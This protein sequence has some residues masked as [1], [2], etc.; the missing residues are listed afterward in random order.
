MK[1]PHL[2]KS[3]EAWVYAIHISLGMFNNAYC[4]TELNSSIENVKSTL[5]WEDDSIYVPIVNSIVMLGYFISNF[6]ILG[7]SDRYGRRGSMILEHSLVIVGSVLSIIP[8]TSTIIIGRALKGLGAGGFFTICAPYINEISP[9]ALAGKLGS[10]VCVSCVFGLA[11]STGLS[12]FLPSQNYST[13][14][15]NNLW[16][17]NLGFPGI[18]SIY[19]L[20][21]FLFVQKLDSPGWYLSNNQKPEAIKALSIIYTAEGIQ[22][23]LDR[24][25]LKNTE[26]LLRPKEKT[27]YFSFIFQRRNR[28]MM[29][30]AVLLTLFKQFT[31]INVVL[32]YSTTIFKEVSGDEFNSR[33]IS[34]AITVINIFSSLFGLVLLDWFGRKTLILIGQGGL[35]LL[36]IL[37]ALFSFFEV[38][39]TSLAICMFLY[40]FIA[41]PTIGS[42]YW[43]FLSETE[44][45]I[46]ISLVCVT[47]TLVTFV[48]MFVFEW[49]IEAFTIVGVFAALAVGSF[50]GVWYIRWDV[51]ETKGKRKAEIEDCLYE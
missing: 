2:Y 40:I 12:L 29:R 44:N 35:G 14:P 42:A 16:M 23:G 18:V 7:Y 19:C 32:A 3:K 51:F 28:K 1:E 27:G 50:V 4:F 11:C 31:G 10:L 30:L 25:K 47:N 41:S 15:L 21:Y 37:F 46:G 49:S 20:Y 38:G 22:S 13:D 24:F 48:F 33:L 36:L 5:N 43:A 17:F 39:I 8:Y 45:D 26:P 9:D 34:F 6:A